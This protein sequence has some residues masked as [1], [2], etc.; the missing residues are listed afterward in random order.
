MVN[1]GVVEKK[2]VSMCEGS[3][4]YGMLLMLAAVDAGAIVDRG[5]RRNDSGR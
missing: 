4:V 2:T 5:G 3:D 1:R